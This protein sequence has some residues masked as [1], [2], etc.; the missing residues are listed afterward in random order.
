MSKINK[1]F[2]T[3]EEDK[4]GNTIINH[5]SDHGTHWPLGRI[6][7]IG[8]VGAILAFVPSVALICYTVLAV[9]KAVLSTIQQG[10]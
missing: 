7:D 5:H 2:C 9:V 1:E 3:N 6:K 10:W 8:L 4:E